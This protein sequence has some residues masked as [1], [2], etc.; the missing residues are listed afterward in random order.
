MMEMKVNDPLGLSR[1]LGTGKY[2]Q[3]KIPIQA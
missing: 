2:D 1:Y 3:K